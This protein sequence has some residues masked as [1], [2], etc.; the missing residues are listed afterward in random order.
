MTHFIVLEPRQKRVFAVENSGAGRDM[1]GNG[2]DRVGFKSLAWREVRFR[3]DHQFRKIRF[4]E[5]LDPGGEGGIAQNE[6]GRAVF[7]RDPGRFNRDIETIFHARRRQHY[8]GAVT[9]PPINSLMQIALLDVGWQT[10]ARAA[11]L[12]IT[13]NKWELRH[14]RPADRLGLERDAR[15]GT[16]GHSEIS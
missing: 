10:C 3:I 2:I 9:V 16:A 13:N 1:L 6:Y 12:N 8:A 5:C 11:P 14:R 15:A 7:A 4:I